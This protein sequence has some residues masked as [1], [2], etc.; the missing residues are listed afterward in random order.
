MKQFEQDPNTGIV[1]F[2]IDDVTFEV[3]VGSAMIFAALSIVLLCLVL[4]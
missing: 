4:S 1:E 2:E 3:L